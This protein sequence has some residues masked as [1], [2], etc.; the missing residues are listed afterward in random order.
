MSAMTAMDPLELVGTICAI[1]MAYAATMSIA[2]QKATPEP[3]DRPQWRPP[4]YRQF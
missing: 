1:I 4:G 3:K 2:K